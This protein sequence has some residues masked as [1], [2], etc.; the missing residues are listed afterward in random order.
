MSG[1]DILLNIYTRQTLLKAWDHE[2][3]QALS[4]HLK[5]PKVFLSLNPINQASQT[6]ALTVNKQGSQT[7]ALTKILRIH[8]V[9]YPSYP[10]WSGLLRWSPTGRHLATVSDTLPSAVWVWGGDTL[11]LVALI[12]QRG[13]VRSVGW[14]AEGDR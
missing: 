6:T 3:D 8:S 7:T 5:A 1:S 14:A 10:L 12:H 2:K 4:E 9:H 13:G 11:A